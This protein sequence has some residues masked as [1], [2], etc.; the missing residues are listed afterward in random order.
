[1]NFL[2]PL[3]VSLLAIAP[4]SGKAKES[5]AIAPIWELKGE[6]ATVFLAGSVHLL[7]E[8][9]LP[10]PAGFDEVYEKSDRV[11]FELDLAEM[12]DPTTALAIQQQ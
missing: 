12:S 8:E 7:R 9:D 11:V 10:L 6:N 2:R 3:L 4:L 1:M 5:P